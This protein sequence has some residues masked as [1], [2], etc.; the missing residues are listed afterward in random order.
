[1]TILNKKCEV[2]GIDIS[3]SIRKKND[4]LKLRKGIPTCLTLTTSIHRLLQADHLR[5]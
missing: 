3:S 1:M 5:I 2:G 4:S